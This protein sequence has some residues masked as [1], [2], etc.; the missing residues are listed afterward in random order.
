MGQK[1]RGNY[2]KFINIE[3]DAQL[4]QDAAI[5]IEFWY[6]GRIENNND[7]YKYGGVSL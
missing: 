6:K 3:L 5:G 4:K 7:F 1:L 2:I